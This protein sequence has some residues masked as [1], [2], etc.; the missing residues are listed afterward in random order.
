MSCSICAYMVVLPA[1]RPRHCPSAGPPAH[2]WKYSAGYLSACVDGAGLVRCAGPGRSRGGSSWTGPGGTGDS[3]PVT[4]AAPRP[5]SLAGRDQEL[6]GAARLAVGGPGPRW[7]AGL[8]QRAA[9]DRQ[10]PAGQE[11]GRPGPAGRAPGA[12][13][14]RRRGSGAPPLWLWRRSCRG[15]RRG[16]LGPA[17]RGSRR[18]RSPVQITRGR[19][20]V[21]GR[22]HGG[23]AITAAAARGLRGRGGSRTCTWPIRPRCS[24]SAS[25]PRSK[26][27]LPGSRLLVL[28]TSRD[29][30][31]NRGRP[32]S[33]T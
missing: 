16:R 28:G 2:A 17:D 20:P 12:V 29:G 5:G 33:A 32:R 30:Q 4:G 18:G 14:P 15:R 10:D 24:C 26:K 27:E 19:R 23:D 3:H 31:A 1:D 11:A 8:G 7:W 25:W 22:G 13:G 21:P 6:A 9:R